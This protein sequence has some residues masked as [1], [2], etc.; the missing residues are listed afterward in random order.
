MKLIL[1]LN[2][3]IMM[4]ERGGRITLPFEYSLKAFSTVSMVS[5]IEINFEIS[6]SE[7]N[8]IDNNNRIIPK[9]AAVI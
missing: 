7:R 9:N 5:S 6:L 3:G 2:S 4:V 1:P 8:N